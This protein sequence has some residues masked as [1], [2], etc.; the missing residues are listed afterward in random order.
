[1]N[2]PTIYRLTIERFRGVKTLE[3]H[4][5]A[6]MNV[7]LGGG[8]VGKTTILDAIGLLLS[9]TNAATLSDADYHQREFKAGFTIEAVMWLPE[10]T[11]VNQQSKPSWPWEWNGK[12][13]VVPALGEAGD[14][15][16]PV[17]V[18]RVSGSP[19]LELLYE[20]VQPSGDT[21]HLSVS[22]RRRPASVG[23]GSAWRTGTPCL[24]PAQSAGSGRSCDIQTERTRPVRPRR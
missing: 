9:P 19:D 11:L 16:K 20:L 2:A 6:G 1:M 4:P 17:Y 15:G 10:E 7:I 12:D 5:S 21:D 18:L 8:D 23:G 24:C 14:V 22:L 13:P 3:W